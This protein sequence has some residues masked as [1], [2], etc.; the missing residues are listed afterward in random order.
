MELLEE[1]QANLKRPKT[2]AEKERFNHPVGAKCVRS[3][4]SNAQQ[5]KEVM[6]ANRSVE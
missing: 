3:L 4:Y 1:E 6:F 5:K 2:A